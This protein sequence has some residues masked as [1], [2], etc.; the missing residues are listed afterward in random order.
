MYN[1]KSEKQL[2]YYIYIFK[3]EFSIKQKKKKRII[4]IIFLEIK[5]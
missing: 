3:K 1:H 4:F 2:F 5:D